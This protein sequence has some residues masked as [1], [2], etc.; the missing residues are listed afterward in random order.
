MAMVADGLSV[1]Y[2]MR[3]VHTKV[4]T[5]IL[6]EIYVVHTLQEYAVQSPVTQELG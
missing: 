4:H 2:V 1:K 3:H 6:E 5:I